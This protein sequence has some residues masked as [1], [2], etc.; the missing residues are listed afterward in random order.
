MDNYYSGPD[1]QETLISVV[2]TGSRKSQS[3]QIQSGLDWVDPD[4]LFL[5]IFLIIS[6][7]VPAAFGL[8]YCLRLGS[9]PATWDEK[10]ME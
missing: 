2:S 10:E 8:G 7:G 4:L 9:S 3:P 5:K 6:M 1:G